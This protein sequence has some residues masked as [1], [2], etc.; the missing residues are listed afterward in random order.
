MPD[1]SAAMLTFTS[2]ILGVSTIYLTL[3]VLSLRAKLHRARASLLT[4]SMELEDDNPTL[5]KLAE[6]WAEE[7]RDA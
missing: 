6:E 2:V 3:L 1:P 7:A 5:A 4:L